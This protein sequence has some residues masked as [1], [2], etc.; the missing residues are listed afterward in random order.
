MGRS[1]LKGVVLGA[2]TAS[3]VLVTSTALAGTGIGGVF[4]LGK[5][6]TVNRTSILTGK[7]TGRVLQ[8]TSKGT[9]PALGLNVQ[10]GKAPLTVNSSTRIANL[11]ADL[12]DGIGRSGRP[13]RPQSNA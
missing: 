6:N 13:S 7:T 5:T 12:L 10:A 11:N 9:G 1:F 8:V 3:I 2:V 4:N